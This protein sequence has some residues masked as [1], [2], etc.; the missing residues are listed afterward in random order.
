[1]LRRFRSARSGRFVPRVVANADPDATVAE[2]S[3]PRI[4]AAI[5]GQKLAAYADHGSGTDIPGEAYSEDPDFWNLEASR[6]L[7]WLHG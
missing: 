7:D 2:T 6:L 4:P 3:R 1:M 5:L